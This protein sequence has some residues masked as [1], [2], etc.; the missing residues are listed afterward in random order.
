MRELVKVVIPLYKQNLHTWEEQTLCHNME[1]L[2]AYPVVFL[3]PEGLDVSTL[4]DR[5][6]WAQVKEVSADWLGTRRGIEGYNTMMMSEAFYALFNDTEYILICHTDAWIFNDRLEEWCRKGYDL[7]A[8]PWPLRPRYRYFPFRQWLWLKRKQAERKQ[9][10][11]RT[12]MYGKIGNGGFCLRRVETFRQACIR[13]ADD[14]R[15]FNAQTGP[16]WN[17]DIFWATVPRGLRLPDVKEALTFAFDL[18]PRLCYRL[19]GRNLPMACHG[20]QHK[21]RKAFWHPFISA[22]DMLR[23]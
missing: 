14:I 6:P 2:Q 21:S 4:T 22:V 17:E 15:R 8:A 5:W 11:S 1:M 10:P 7:V 16:M 18:K 23:P 9:I 3:K 20:F 19:N 13:H 12:S